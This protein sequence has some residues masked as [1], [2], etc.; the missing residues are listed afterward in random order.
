MTK[1]ERI[2]I[3][4][5]KNIVEADC[6]LEN[7][8]VIVG[9]N[10]SG[11]TNLLMAIPLLNHI[12]NGGIENVKIA[13]D[14]G[15]LVEN[16]GWIVTSYTAVKPIIMGI[17]FSDSDTNTIYNY[18]LHLSGQK[19]KQ[20]TFDP[21]MISSERFSFKR[22][23]KTGKPITIFDRKGSEVSYGTGISN[24]EIISKVDSYSSVIRLLSLI[25][26]SEK[27]SIEYK[28]ALSKLSLIL[29]SP[30]FYFSPQ[31]FKEKKLDLKAES[32]MVHFD[33]AQELWHLKKKPNVWKE[34]LKTTKNLLKID[35]I[36]INEK[37]MKT[38]PQ[39]VSYRQGG[40][41]NFVHELSD[42]T[43]IL[44]ALII[45]IFSDSSTIFLIEEPENSI[46]PRAL[47]ELMKL[48]REKSLDK[49]F[50]ITT[51]S[52]YLLN[53][54]QPEEVLVAERM[55]NGLSKIKKISNIKAIKKKLSKT[56][57]NFGDIVFA[58]PE[59]DSESE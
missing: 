11:K 1:L 25:S 43:V 49:Q 37:I 6:P 29:S 55:S 18:E 28:E 5:Y 59:S 19:V 24:K 35:D 32:R 52:S 4:N 3:Q 8:N 2:H 17:E 9:E 14:S 50:I 53:M 13:F 20:K 41:P 36:S 23:N 38:E 10:N 56:F 12:V 31:L 16:M 47:Y 15:G 27:I 48:I 57:M 22:K 44:L 42:G 54:I 34:F 51:H 46:H 40:L 26:K 21:I 30:I 39:Y 58:E 7:M 45:K 33:L